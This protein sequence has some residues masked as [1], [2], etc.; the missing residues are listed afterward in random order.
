MYLVILW[1]LPVRQRRINPVV[2]MINLISTVYQL[3]GL[4]SSASAS[5]SFSSDLEPRSLEMYLS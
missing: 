4:I 2:V 5:R 1:Y 3:S